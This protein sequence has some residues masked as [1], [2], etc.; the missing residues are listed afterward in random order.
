MSP[1]QATG[2]SPAQTAPPA[3]EAP[4]ARFAQPPSSTAAPAG[5]PIGPSTLHADEKKAE[6]Q[7]PRERGREALLAELI[8]S[9]RAI[10]LGAPDCTTACRALR[11]MSRAAGRACE[12]PVPTGTEVDCKDIDARVGRARARVTEAC[13]VCPDAP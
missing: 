4:G 9:E 5:T 7:A 1:M 8:S 10:L 3:P 6:E 12:P 13:G 2:A 11:S